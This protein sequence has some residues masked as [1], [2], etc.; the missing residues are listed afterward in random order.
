M[1]FYFF[2]KH[3]ITRKSAWLNSVLLVALMVKWEKKVI[4]FAVSKHFAPES[5][6]SQF[7]TRPH[8]TL[9][10]ER[11][12]TKLPNLLAVNQFWKY[13]WIHNWGYT[14][15]I[16]FKSSFRITRAFLMFSKT[17]LTRKS[18][19]TSTTRLLYRMITD[20]KYW[21]VF[22]RTFKPVSYCTYHLIG[23]WRSTDPAQSP[24]YRQRKYL[25]G[26]LRIQLNHP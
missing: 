9:D 24:Q 10:F 17:G 12:K 23:P 19:D 5:S 3:A 7:R 15:N 6:A 26:L 4:N 21:E 22:P 25:P 1:W 8:P 20:V 11:L 16:L 13:K 2:N 14:R 18:W